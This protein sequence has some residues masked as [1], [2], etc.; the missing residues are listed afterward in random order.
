MTL[1][2]ASICNKGKSII[3]IGDRMVSFKSGPIEYESE[4]ND[5]K[6]YLFHNNVMAFAG[7]IRDIILLKNR[8]ESKGIDVVKFASNV[9]DVIKDKIQEETDNLIYRFTR[10]DRDA[11]LQDPYQGH[12]CQIPID[13]KDLV[14]SAFPQIQMDC[15]GIIGGFDENQKA[16]MYL[17]NPL[18]EFREMT[19][20]WNFSI[21]SGQ[22]FSEI[23]FDQEDYTSNCTLQEGLYFAY[24]AKKFAESHVG[25][26]AKTD[27]VILNKD[28]APKF[29][30]ADK[31]ESGLLAML[32]AEYFDERKHLEGFRKNI[33]N[34]IK[35]VLK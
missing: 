19:D 25:V 32:E 4:A 18:G 6:I 12:A 27:I 16:R 24:R 15:H 9:S 26:G 17:I 5:S 13:I 8:I 11:F 31:D 20:F 14:Y 22:P 3:I 23:F 21:G 33:F 10:H 2:Q 29:Y 1:V 30:N 28:S 35:E 34:K 7:S